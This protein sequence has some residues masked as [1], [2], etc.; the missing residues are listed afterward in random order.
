MTYLEAKVTILSAGV[1]LAVE[2]VVYVFYDL[3]VT[4]VVIEDP[5]C[6]RFDSDGA[7]NSNGFT[8]H[9]VS[10]YF[11]L[12]IETEQKCRRLEKGLRRLEKEHGIQTKV[13][14][15]RVDE[16]DWSESWKTFFRPERIGHRLVVK[17]TWHEYERRPE[18]IVLELDPGM[19]FG[20]GT[21]PTTSLCLR[22][23]ETYLDPGQA[24]LDIG[25]GSGILMIAAAKLG[26]AKVTGIDNDSVAVQ[27]A[28]KNL[29]QN[30]IPEETFDIIRGNLVA[31]VR[32]KYNL[33]AANILAE[34]IIDL[35][36]EIRGV[37]ES[38]AVFIASGIIAERRDRVVEKIKAR[39]FD[40]LKI[41][42]REEW[43]AIAARLKS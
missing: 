38:R 18:D 14:Y 39:N 40:V 4:G 16:Q 37:L 36:D 33:V 8:N 26:A 43:V 20:T 2:L 13:V 32:G 11:P 6:G 35:L 17:P 30:N 10:A 24:F 12:D 5:K 42:T 34:V 27:V 1:E 25:S 19:A 3:N 41:R 15:H 21:H 28:T 29:L 31:S 23:I 22:M 7:P 9:A